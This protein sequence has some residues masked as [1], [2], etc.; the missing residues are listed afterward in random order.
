[1]DRTANGGIHEPVDAPLPEVTSVRS[2]PAQANAVGGKM[3]AMKH[4]RHN[5]SRLTSGA[6]LAISM[7]ML[8]VGRDPIALQRERMVTDQLESRGVRNQ[9]VLQVMRSIPRHL[10]IPADLRSMAYEDHPVP[11]GHGAT[12]S[13]PYIVAFMT[14]LLAPAKKHRILEIGTGSGYQAAI[15]GQLG[16]EVYT[17]E[18]VPE[19]ASSAAKTLGDLGY[20]N[21]RVRQGDGYKGW[22]EQAPFDRMIITAAPLV[23]PLALIAQL[24]E[25]GRLVAPVGSMWMQEL[26]VIEKRGDGTIRRRSVCPVN[27]V[28]MRRADK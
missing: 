7:S 25:N 17:V 26:V 5:P 12:I 20:G 2:R 18:I 6:I 19:L 27:F 3:A 4:R 24:A 15:L 13:Q 14:E 28:P 22:P 23:V 1:M 11:I 8:L 10:F 21:I 16:A 9:D